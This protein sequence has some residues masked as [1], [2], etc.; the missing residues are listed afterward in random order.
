MQ[1]IPLILAKPDMLLARDVYRPHEGLSAMP[2]CGSGT[3]LTDDLLARLEA[4]GVQTIYVEGHPVWEEGGSSLDD[5]L[6]DL[7]KRFEKVRHDPLTSMLYDIH[8]DYLR[9]SMGD[10]GGRQ[11]Q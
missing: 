11:T 5:L 4:L 8:V 7:E 10:A 2:I 3:K 9:R 6:A 1:K